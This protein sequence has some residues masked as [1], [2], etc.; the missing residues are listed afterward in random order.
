MVQPSVLNKA[1]TPSET[2]RTSPVLSH[3]PGPAVAGYKR[4]RVAEKKYYAVKEGRTPGVYE[5]WD[6]CRDQVRGQ[7]G[8]VCKLIAF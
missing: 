8:A 5:T 3:I 4:K 2:A 6:E 7:K 1:T